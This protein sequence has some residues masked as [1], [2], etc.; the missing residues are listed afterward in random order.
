MRW[1]A[2]CDGEEDEEDWQDVDELMIGL[3]LPCCLVYNFAIEQIETKVQEELETLL[4]CVVIV[5]IGI[6]RLL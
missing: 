3:S 4:C 1:A 5:A 2:H 6:Q